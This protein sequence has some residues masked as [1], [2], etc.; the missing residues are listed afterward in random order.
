MR[1]FKFFHVFLVVSI[2]FYFIEAS[3][4][5]NKLGIDKRKSVRK[6]SS[7]QKNPPSPKL[8]T[9]AQVTKNYSK[10]AV[11]AYHREFK[12][13]WKT[14]NKCRNLVE[15]LSHKPVL[16]ENGSDIPEYVIED[17][18][19]ITYF[20]P[21]EPEYL[22]EEDQVN[23]KGNFMA[24]IMAQYRKDLGF[25]PVRPFDEA[26]SREE[27][28]EFLKCFEGA[29]EELTRL[30]LTKFDHKLQE[31]YQFL[32]YLGIIPHFDPETE[33]FSCSKIREQTGFVNIKHMLEV[34]EEE[35][36][37]FTFLNWDYLD[38]THFEF[39]RFPVIDRIIR[40]L[41]S[42]INPNYTGEGIMTV[43]GR[44]ILEEHVE[45]IRFHNPRTIEGRRMLLF[46]KIYR[47][48]YKAMKAAGA[49]MNQSFINWYYCSVSGWPEGISLTDLTTWTDEQ[50]DALQEAI[51]TD[52]LK[53]SQITRHSSSSL[54][55][56][57]GRVEG[58]DALPVIRA[59][60]AFKKEHSRNVCSLSDDEEVCGNDRFRRDFEELSKQ[61][62][63]TEDF[64]DEE[65]MAIA[66]KRISDVRSR[67]ERALNRTVTQA[68]AA[69]SE[70]PVSKPLKTPKK[71]VKN[72]SVKE[73]EDSDS[74]N[75]F[76]RS[77]G[78]DVTRTKKPPTEESKVSK[79][80]T[81]TV[82]VKRHGSDIAQLVVNVSD[83]RKLAS[84]TDREAL[85]A[86]IRDMFREDTDRSGPIDWGLVQVMKMEYHR[87]PFNK[88]LR[89][90]NDVK[91]ANFVIENNALAFLNLNELVDRRNRLYER[92]Y[93]MY[94]TA[95]DPYPNQFDIFFEDLEITGWPEGVEFEFSV[96][97]SKEVKLL[98]RLMDEEKI[99]FKIS[100]ECEERNAKELALAREQEENEKGTNEVDGL[101]QDSSVSPPINPLTL[102]SQY[103][104]VEFES[105]VDRETPQK[106]PSYAN[107]VNQEEFVHGRKRKVTKSFEFPTV[108]KAK[109]EESGLAGLGEFVGCS[110]EH[111]EE[112][113]AKIDGNIAEVL[114]M[115]SRHP[116]DSRNYRV[117]TEIL[118]CLGLL[119]DHIIYSIDGKSL[120]KLMRSEIEGFLEA[121]SVAA[122]LI[123]E[124][125][126][127]I[128]EVRRKF[129]I[130][131]TKLRARLSGIPYKR[132]NKSLQIT[133][134]RIR[135]P[136]LS[137]LTAPEKDWD[138]DLLEFFQSNQ[139]EEEI[140]S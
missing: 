96:W 28:F 44:A 132:G 102:L 16:W 14:L 116:F 75:E 114:E 43:S 37:L 105:P 92:L 78:I 48:Y 51:K 21:L 109:S 53:F 120:P 54:K 19:R 97:T 40:N 25:S 64:S 29:E 58:F 68:Q 95:C 121:F 2:F 101:S 99:S 65:T 69:E 27:F 117:Y 86:E 130:N 98:E 88:D 127:L 85:L 67:K 72:N 47:L 57:L 12:S 42:N 20:K 124:D 50:I 38:L 93:K 79:T 138:V 83:D 62:E 115:R 23:P 39:Q 91:I 111:L 87:L 49:K 113:K 24:R 15:N 66:Q 100:R 26:Y 119:R 112:L 118:K 59:V 6:D 137:F 41:P 55:A 131:A 108:S 80:R 140:F 122:S 1:Q 89:T 3:R 133:S 76:L 33:M 134:N 103:Q 107:Y 9:F 56:W 13:R 90:V 17:G 123:T 63:D 31:A 125:G 60:F 77:A 22:V 94:C 45:H 126:T 5:P 52:A 7:L 32:K 74:D 84:R 139:G 82:I 73:P 11:D 129:V 136:L 71:L 4:D 128:E 34:Y 104:K 36:K 8:L 10:K 106:T 46:Q 135:N 35:S 81:R 110:F 61:F 70:S 18:K 30:G